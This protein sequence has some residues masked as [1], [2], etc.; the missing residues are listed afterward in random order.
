[1]FRKYITIHLSLAATCLCAS[2]PVSP[3]TKITLEEAQALALK[4]HPQVMEARGRVLIANQQVIENRA[5]YYPSIA[6]DVTAGQGNVNA[7]IGAGFFTTSRLFN[8]FGQ[9]LTLN[10]L[11][12]DSGRTP[13]LVASSRLQAESS[14]QNYQATKDDVMLA[15][16]QAY[17]GV[18][19]AR[20]L[21]RV[22]EKT[23][24]A[25]QLL[26]DQVAAL[27]KANLK[28]QLDVSFADVNLADARLL[29]LRAQDNVEQANAELSRA[30][31]TD[32]DVNY[33][34]V[35]EP[36][37][38]S[39]PSSAEEL[40]AQAIKSRP[41]LASLR[42]SVQSANRFY[43]AEKDLKRPSVTMLAVGGGLPLVNQLGSTPIAPEYEG[44]V[45]NVQVPVFNGRLFSARAE[46]ARIQVTAAEQ[47]LRD[48]QLRI[49]RDV[50]V[51]WSNAVTAYLRL[52]VTAQYL[53]EASL[54]Q[55]L[56]QGRY[57][58]G[59][60]SIIELSQAQ[61]SVTSAEIENLSAKYD[62][63]TLYAVL[64]HAAGL[65]K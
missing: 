3:T 41:E 7:R 5:A 30:L 6:A 16:N 28:S 42:L 37:P 40:T 1:M 31:G 52:D 36:Q 55:S 38:A 13:N 25:R 43:D 47:R 32:R 64:Q 51:A 48:E 19:R 24:A 15:V 35:E 27:A 61:L 54:A 18:L 46:A 14:E 63:Q 12:T 62:Y 4:N 10:Q 23:L 29:L 34:P 59:L 11:I 45:V 8:R 9:G 17:F 50:R 21:V 44:V 53:R 22:A 58:L 20:A 39:P 56:A 33:D 26:S 60:S 2:A 49:T 65:L 57:N